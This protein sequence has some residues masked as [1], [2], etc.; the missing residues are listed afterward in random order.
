MKPSYYC[1]QSI[2]VNKVWYGDP[3]S[4]KITLSDGKLDDVQVRTCK[5]NYVSLMK[6]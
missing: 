4:P 5:G 3:P 6:E 2:T 1:E